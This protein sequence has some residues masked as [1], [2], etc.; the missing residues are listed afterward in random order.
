M[1]G[2]GT[3]KPK[4]C[5]SSHVICTMTLWNLEIERI[6]KSVVRFRGHVFAREKWDESPMSQTREKE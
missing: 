1:D 2:I 5:K 4:A 6:R 3:K